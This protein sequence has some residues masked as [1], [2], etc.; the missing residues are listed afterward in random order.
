MKATTIRTIRT[1][2][3]MCAV[4]AT[5]AVVAGQ[6][7]NPAYKPPRT[8]D[9]QPDLQGIWQ[10]RN[11]AN[12]DVQSHG[13]LLELAENQGRGQG[14]RDRGRQTIDFQAGG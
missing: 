7:A 5:A 14:R 6:A 1:G 11:T 3:L 12:W 10:V 13:R 8:P 4:A 2:V 9:G